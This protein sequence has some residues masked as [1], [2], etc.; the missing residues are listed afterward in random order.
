VTDPTALLGLQEVIGEH[1][2]RVIVEPEATQPL[3]S[4]FAHGELA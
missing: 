3:Q 1:R 2:R 4:L